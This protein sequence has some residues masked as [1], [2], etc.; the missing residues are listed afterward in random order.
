MKYPEEF[1]QYD[2]YCYDIALKKFGKVRRF[3]FEVFEG[4]WYYADVEERIEFLKLLKKHGVEFILRK[5]T[6]GGHARIYIKASD[7]DKVLKLFKKF[8]NI[9]GGDV[10]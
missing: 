9:E 3:D 10:R 8:M 1:E 5:A 6:R 4:K 7:Y 2:G